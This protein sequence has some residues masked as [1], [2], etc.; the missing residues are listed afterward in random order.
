M[1][2]HRTRAIAKPV[3]AAAMFLLLQSPSLFAFPT[4][5]NLIPTADMLEPGQVRIELENDAYSKLF[6]GDLSENYFLT[7][8][9]VTE[10]LE[11][12]VD[13]YDFSHDGGYALNGKFLLAPET[14]G[15]PAFAVGVMDVAEG[16]SPTTYSVA[17]KTWGGLRGHLGGWHTGGNNFLM[18]GSDYE[19]ND[20][21][22]LMT[23]WTSGSEGYLTFGFWQRLQGEVWLNAAVGRANNRDNNDL[24]LL[25]L[26]YIFKP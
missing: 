24:V 25:N 4:S 5:E 26:S 6:E 2:F 1:R 23:D 9:G 15:T 14:D 3:I 7:Q 19:V 13:A 17:T 10:R 22:Y 16:S 11:V 12:G 20:D 8:V 21:L 18:A